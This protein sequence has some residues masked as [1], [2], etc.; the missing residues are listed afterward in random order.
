MYS[1]EKV[2][3][4][5][6]GHDGDEVGLNREPEASSPNQIV[7]DK[8]FFFKCNTTCKQ[9]SELERESLLKSG[10]FQFDLRHPIFSER[11]PFSESWSIA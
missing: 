5:T 7:I 10:A 9:E 6:N 2:K 8:H 1:E 3:G 4:R 11:I